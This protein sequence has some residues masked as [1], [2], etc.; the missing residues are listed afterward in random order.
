MMASP[1]N[2]RPRIGELLAPALEIAQRHDG[3]EIGRSVR[4]QLLQVGLGFIAA[5]EPIEIDGALDQRA[6]LQRRIGRHPFIGLDGELG[7]LQPLI[8]IRQRK[9]RHLMRGHQIERELQ[10]DQAE[11]FPPRRPSAAPSP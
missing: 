7:L 5:I 8:E 1:W 3:L 10:I 11:I 9:Q 6:A 4:D 2:R